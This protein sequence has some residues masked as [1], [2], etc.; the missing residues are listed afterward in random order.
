MNTNFLKNFLKLRVFSIL[1]VTTIIF[2]AFLTAGAI[3]ILALLGP[4]TFIESERVISQSVPTEIVSTY[5]KQGIGVPLPVPS[6]EVNA[7]VRDGWSLDLPDNIEH[8]ARC[9]HKVVVNGV[10]LKWH[11]SH[12]QIFESLKGACSV[13]GAGPTGNIYMSLPDSA[14]RIESIT[15]QWHLARKSGVIRTP[16]EDQSRNRLGL[17]GISLCCIGSIGIAL[18]LLLLAKD[19]A[20]WLLAGTAGSASGLVVGCWLICLSDTNRGLWLSTFISQSVLYISLFVMLFGLILSVLVRWINPFIQ[21]RAPILSIIILT[22]GVSVASLESGWVSSQLPT[23]PYSP[24]GPMSS[25]FAGRIP[26]SDA[27]NWYAGMRKLNSGRPV[28]WAA[29]RPVHALIRS[30]EF[31]MA[32]GDYQWSLIIQAGVFALTVSALTIAAWSSLTPAVALIIWVGAFRVGQGFLGSYL[33]ESVGYSCACLSLAYLLVGCKENRFGVRVAGIAWLGMAW[34]TRPGPLG[35]LAVPIVLEALAPF[36][37]RFRRMAIAVAVLG[38]VLL[39]GKAVFQ[40]VASNG[41]AENANAAQ[42]IYGLAIGKRWNEAYKEF[43]A[44]APERVNL[45]LAEQT[46][47]MQREA[48]QRLIA[49]PQP[50]IDKFLTDLRTGFNNSILAIPR[51]LWTA[52]LT[53]WLLLEKYIGWILLIGGLVTTAVLIKQRNLVGPLLSGSVIALIVSLPIISDAGGLRSTIIAAPSLVV[54]FCLICA[55]P[56]YLCSSKV[57]VT[58]T[59]PCLNIVNAGSAIIILALLTGVATYLLRNS[60]TSVPAIPMTI[61]TNHD[62]FVFITDEHPSSNLSGATMLTRADAVQS[63]RDRGMSTYELDDFVGSISPDSI[64]AFKFDFG[65]GALMLL[66]ENIGGPRFG[67]LIV[68]A[69]EPTANSYF[70]R[71]TKWKWAEK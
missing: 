41:A 18:S 2:A 43:H 42:V 39:G 25:L 63:L 36:A 15:I 26:F 65:E 52:L 44:F 11:H 57:G 3:L 50:A 20:T 46:S 70:T 69:T 23:S 4:T 12:T 40:L 48:W 47:L 17:A 31:E 5:G 7:L 13:W 61:F 68:E 55:M 45:S 67:E 6:E 8:P 62:P 35:L 56:E 33:S 14:D 22:L 27:G 1:T 58:T 16:Q 28:S 66:I 9:R 51:M 64:I 10:T 60:P 29:R 34:L 24:E 21:V 49:K 71:A 38:G 53:P 54:F 32:R 30:G 19:W 37:H 59:R